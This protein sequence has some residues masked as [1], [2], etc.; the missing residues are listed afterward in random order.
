M[1]ISKAASR[2]AKCRHVSNP[3][4]ENDHNYVFD[5]KAEHMAYCESD[6]KLSQNGR[7]VFC[8]D[9]EDIA[10]FNP[11]GKGMTIASACNLFY[12]HE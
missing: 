11:M 5:F 4:R 6:V 3:G 12:H 9:F 8:Q 7:E 1:A 10:D 2:I